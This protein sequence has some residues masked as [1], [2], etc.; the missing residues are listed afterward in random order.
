MATETQATGMGMETEHT[1]VVGDTVAI[2]GDLEAAGEVGPRWVLRSVAV[3]EQELHQ[4][5]TFL[6]DTHFVDVF[7]PTT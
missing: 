2:R 6:K 1:T 4:V 3:R 5:G 7:R